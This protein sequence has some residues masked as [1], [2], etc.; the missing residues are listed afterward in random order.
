[1]TVDHQH[2]SGLAVERGPQL[3]SVELPCLRLHGG[4]VRIGW[5]MLEISA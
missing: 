1:M 4:L 3:L 5:R 2:D